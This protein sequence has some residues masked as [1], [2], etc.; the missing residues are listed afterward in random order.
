MSSNYVFV[1]DMARLNKLKQEL[2]DLLFDK[3][4]TISKP[5][6]DDLATYVYHKEDMVVFKLSSQQTTTAPTPAQE[7]GDE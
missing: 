2:T 4:Y 1:Y 6:I 3:G 5:L 7:V